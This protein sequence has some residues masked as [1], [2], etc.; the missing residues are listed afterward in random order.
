MSDDTPRT[1]AEWRELVDAEADGRER[2]SSS[3]LGAGYY[4]DDVRAVAAGLALRWASAALEVH[5]HQRDLDG[6]TNFASQALDS[7]AA[8]RRRQPLT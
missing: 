4:S 8:S 5:V 3:P 7:V 2:R 6:A 1:E